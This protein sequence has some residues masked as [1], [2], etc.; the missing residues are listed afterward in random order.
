M[1]LKKDSEDLSLHTNLDIF[2]LPLQQ[3]V[4]LNIIYFVYVL[5]V[6][7]MRYKTMRISVIKSVT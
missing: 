3:V 2:L 6:I 5:H 7:T 1:Q 4:K